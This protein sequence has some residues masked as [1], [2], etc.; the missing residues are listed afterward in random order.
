MQAPSLTEYGEGAMFFE[1]LGVHRFR[2]GS[3]TNECKAEGSEGLCKNAET[4][5]C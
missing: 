4:N 2:L 5:K 1:N 3:E